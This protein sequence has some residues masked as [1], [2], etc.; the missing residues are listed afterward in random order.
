MK[1]IFWTILL[2]CLI[3]SVQAEVLWVENFDYPIGDE[4]VGANGWYTQYSE[5]SGISITSGLNLPHYAAFAPNETSDA[6]NSGAALLDVVSHSAQPHHAFAQITDGEVYAS[7]LLLP[8]INY[9]KSYFFCLRDEKTD[10]SNYSDFNYNGR[11]FLNE[12]NQVGL[13]FADNQ[14]AVF[15]SESLDPNQVYLLVLRY[16][17]VPGANNDSVSLYVLADG[18]ETQPAS[19]TLGPIADPA[20]RDINPANVVLRGYDADGWLVVDGI[21]VATTWAEAAPYAETS[22]AV[23]NPQ[24]DTARNLSSAKVYSVLG[25]NL[26]TYGQVR[27]ALPHGIYILSTPQ[28]SIKIQL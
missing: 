28:K 17:I 15:S 3:G 8:S 19:P 9:K 18:V 11:V 1:K 22:T 24:S 13:T 12:Y 25:V 5:L 14:K 20:K 16:Q 26:G 10:A 7:F 23:L 6:Q 2:V 4:L 27:D 21:R